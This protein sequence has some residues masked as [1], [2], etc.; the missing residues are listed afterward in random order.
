MGGE[1]QCAATLGAVLPTQAGQAPHLTHAECDEDAAT[2]PRGLRDRKSQIALARHQEG[3][4]AVE[5]VLH[6]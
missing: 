4:V 5:N 3:I 1:L 2:L 6:V